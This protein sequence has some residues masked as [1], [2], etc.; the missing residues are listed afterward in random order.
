MQT[1]FDLTVLAQ[2]AEFC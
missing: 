2:C 1:G